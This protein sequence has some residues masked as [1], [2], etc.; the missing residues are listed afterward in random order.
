[1]RWMAP[2]AG[3]A[4]ALTAP[5]S[6]SEIR[7]S[8]QMRARVEMI[9]GQVRPGFAA[10]DIIVALRTIL[11]AEIET[12][13]LTFA[14]EVRDSRVYLQEP[15]SAVSDRDVNVL[16]PVRL[17]LRI[18]LR[19]AAPGGGEA[20]LVLGRQLLGIGSNR[21]IDPPDY[22]NA[23]N[24]FTGLKLEARRG[25]WIIEAAWAM[26]QQRLPSDREEV[27]QNRFALDR[28]GLDR[29]IW[30][31]HLFRQEAIGPVGAGLTYVGFREEDRPG[32]PTRNRRLHTLGPWLLRTPAPGQLDLDAEAFLQWGR[33]RASAAEP[34]PDLDVLAGFARL[35]VGAS[36]AG[37]W[38]PR[39]SFRIDW[40]SG[41]RPG[42]RFE[43][44]DRLFGSRV[45][46]FAVSGQYAAV[47]RANILSPGLRLAGARG[48][49]DFY[50]TARLL[51]AD[52]VTDSFSTTGVQD[53]TGASGRFAGA[54]VE[55]RA[56]HWLRRDRLRLETAFVVLFRDG[57]LTDAPNAPPGRTLVYLA[58]ALVASF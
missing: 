40:A 46:D 20:R 51:W 6:A 55:G 57:L 43:R 18:D 9:D 15:D 11:S 52:S 48:G 42:D 30:A 32:L 2:A 36:L 17:E 8:G 28:E 26:P 3:L 37:A 45:A 53:P 16:E 19:E 24:A 54:Q 50:V 5:A 14:G 10:R 31:V 35:E 41:D 29:Q 22:R 39:L 44:F 12:G 56:R 25:P 33:I 49:T 21:L 47:G 1:M 4:L 7:L 34:A 13:A 27:R 58:P 38:R 23:T